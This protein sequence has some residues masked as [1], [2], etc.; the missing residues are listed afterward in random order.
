MIVSS[1][2]RED[3]FQ[4][5]LRFRLDPDYVDVLFDDVSGGVSAIHRE[6]KF[7][8]QM[9]AFGVRIGEYERMAVN[10]LRKNGHYVVLASE[11]APNGVKTPDGILDGSI[12]DIKSIEGKSFWAVKD[13]LHNA[14]KQGVECVVLYFHKKELYSP[15][16]IEDG[17]HRFLNDPSSQ[18]HF[19]TIKQLICIVEEKEIEYQINKKPPFGGF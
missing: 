17:W 19:N 10:V 5:Y 9:G 8:K 11:L 15:L 18:K 4:D 2:Q 6:H 7:D 1:L 16:R 14:I 13:K 12:M 3:N